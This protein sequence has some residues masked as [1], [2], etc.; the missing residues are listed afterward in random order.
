[1]ATIYHVTRACKLQSILRDGLLAARSL[2]KRKAV[3]AVPARLIAWACLHVV[4]RHGGRIEDVVVLEL[5]VPPSWLKR[6]KGGTFYIERDV[7][8]ERIG[9]IRS[10]RLFA[11]AS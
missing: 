5:N 8:A 11:R 4:T 1:M 10:Y 3:W 6:H 2:G 7:P 9:S